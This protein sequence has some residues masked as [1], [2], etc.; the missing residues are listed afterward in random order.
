MK[1]ISKTIRECE[2]Q[3]WTK[4]KVLELKYTHKKMPWTVL[5]RDYLEENYDLILK[6]LRKAVRDNYNEYI[7][8]Q[9]KLKDL[10]ETSNLKR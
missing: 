5:I 6:E 4:T 8:T 9:N 7:E 2:N 1:I 3:D 10:C